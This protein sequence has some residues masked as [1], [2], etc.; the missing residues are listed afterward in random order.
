MRISS[1]API[2]PSVGYSQ[3]P[4]TSP[5][6]LPLGPAQPQGTTVGRRR[7]WA[8]RD[9]ALPPSVRITEDSESVA[10]PAL[11]L[12]GLART[13]STSFCLPVC[14]RP[15]SGHPQSALR[16]LRDRPPT[17]EART[18]T[19]QPWTTPT[20]RTGT[21]QRLKA[22][23]LA[24]GSGGGAAVRSVALRGWDRGRSAG[25][26]Q[27]RDSGPVRTR[28]KANQQLSQDRS[29]CWWGVCVWACSPKQA[30]SKQHAPGA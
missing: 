10:L 30:T 13:G 15:K 4:P 20:G 3:I 17:R 27:G 9:A 5:V 12:R 28:A 24:T 18:G 2:P 21:L 6:V 19:S 1:S 16:G 11:V 8:G 29:Q 26:G 22:T 14:S 23:S 25:R 7:P